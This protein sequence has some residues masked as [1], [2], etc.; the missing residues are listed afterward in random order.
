MDIPSN[1]DLDKIEALLA[2]GKLAALIG[3]EH[4]V[5]IGSRDHSV[6]KASTKGP[7]GGLFSVF[8]SGGDLESLA[9]KWAPG[10]MTVFATADGLDFSFNLTKD[11]ALLPETLYVET[12]DED[13]ELED[14]EV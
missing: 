2:S 4:P 8:Y 12:D 14:E 9:V 10:V 11:F 3:L 13:E 5:E 6:V 7:S 1:I